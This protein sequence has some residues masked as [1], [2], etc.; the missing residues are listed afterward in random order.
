MP[1]VKAI[2]GNRL[3]A[4]LLDGY[5]G[6]TAYA[7]QQTDE[8]EIRTGHTISGRRP[9]GPRGA[10]TVR[11]SS[12]GFQPANLGCQTSNG[13]MRACSRGFGGTRGGAAYGY[14]E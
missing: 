6:R 5:L 13:D 8:P 12:Q 7:S 3:A 11:R 2:I 1:T 9:R 4:G 10:R 14:N